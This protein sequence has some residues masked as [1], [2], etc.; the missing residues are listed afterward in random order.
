[1]VKLIMGL[2]GAGKTKQLVQDINNA[3]K[4]EAG[5]IV[6]IEKGTKLRYDINMHVRLIDFQ[7]YK[8]LGS[9]QFLKGFISGLHAGNFDISHVF[10]DSFYKLVENAGVAEL[11]DFMLW[12][13]KF[14]ATNN[15]SF[16]V[17]VSEDPA[18]AT[19]ALKAFM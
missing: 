9:L 10:I 5:S 17:V 11:E 6:C 16:T 12:C 14:G 13:E 4:E 19:E 8:L 15:L 3:V 1:M 2:K 18:N 7:E